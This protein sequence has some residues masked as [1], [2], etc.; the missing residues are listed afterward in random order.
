MTFMERVIG[1]VVGTLVF[2]IVLV[3]ADVLVNFA[4]GGG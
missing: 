4:R 2:V 3:F 1:F